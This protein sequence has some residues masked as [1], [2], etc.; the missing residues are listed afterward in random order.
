M[1]PDVFESL[2]DS[3][4]AA[5][6]DPRNWEKVLAAL[7][8]HLSGAG[9]GL[10][11]MTLDGSSFAFGATYR[12]DPEALAAYA[13]YYYAV[14]PLNA[15]LS[16]IPVGAAVPDQQL[17]VPSD[18]KRTEFYNDYGRRFDIAGSVTLLLARDSR[19]E[20]SLG[21]VRG[22]GSDLFTDE[23]VAF[24]QRLSPH[25]LR[26]I[27]LNRRLASLE[28]E[29]QSFETALDRIETAVLLLDGEGQIYYCNAAGTKLLKRVDGLTASRGRLSAISSSAQMTL[30]GHIQNALAVK[31]ARGGSVSVPRQHSARPL[32]VRIMPFAQKS[33]FWIA[34]TGAR[35]IVFISDPDRPDGDSITGVMDAYGLTPAEKKLVA[36]LLAGRSL[37]EAAANL[38]ITRVTS[39]NRLARIMAKTDTHRQGQLLQLILRSST[40]L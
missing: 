22:V 2:L 19:Q 16:H 8:S 3:I 35:A 33:D 36:E 29:R 32:I 39:R 10:H 34:A 25:I 21:I 28:V 17:V 40:S 14:N 11:A 12:V 37:N 6:E 1:T 27:G 31:G 4:Y 13:E 38:N 26:A 20:A 30:A 18:L 15:A 9:G 7:T 23:Q 24:V 5:G